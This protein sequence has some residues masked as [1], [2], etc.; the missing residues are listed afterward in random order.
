MVTVNK[1]YQYFNGK[2][3][4]TCD[5]RC[6]S[7]DDKPTE[8]IPNGTP[9]IEIDTGEKAMFDEENKKWWPIS[10]SVVI[11]PASGVSF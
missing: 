2:L 4:E 11:D 6:L 3:T 8:G 9:A 5:V 10:S 1:H 7:D